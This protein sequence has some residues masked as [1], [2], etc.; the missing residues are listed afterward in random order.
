MAT[1]TDLAV[2]IAQDINTRLTVH[3][4][5]AAGVNADTLT[6]TGI[7]PMTAV[8]TDWSAQNF[9]ASGRGHFT[10]VQLLAGAIQQ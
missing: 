3:P 6:A 8:P 10:V 1:L 9:P 7:Y 5:L 4:P 2:R